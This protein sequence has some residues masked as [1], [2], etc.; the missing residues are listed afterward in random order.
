MPDAYI[1]EENVAAR[2]TYL[3]STLASCGVMTDEARRPTVVWCLDI[4]RDSQKV[5]HSY[6]YHS[7]GKHWPIF[8][9]LSLLN[10][11]RICGESLNLLPH[12]LVKSTWTIQ[13][14]STVQIDERCL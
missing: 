7:F 9:I 5:R 1:H 14:C 2:F 3:L 12:Y 8:I 4:H 11:E 10:S 6:F 13:F